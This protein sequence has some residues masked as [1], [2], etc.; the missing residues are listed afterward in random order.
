M[1]KRWPS[2]TS[3]PGATSGDAAP[4]AGTDGGGAD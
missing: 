4:T 3:A 2:S 1:A